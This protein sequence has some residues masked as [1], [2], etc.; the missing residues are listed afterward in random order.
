MRWLEPFQRARRRLMQLLRPRRQALPGAEAAPERFKGYPKGAD[1]G[2]TS[3]LGDS[4]S[5]GSRKGADL[6]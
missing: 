6:G 5:S 2:P 1:V 4:S 3:Y